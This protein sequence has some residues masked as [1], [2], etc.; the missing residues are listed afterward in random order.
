MYLIIKCSYLF[1]VILLTGSALK[2][3]CSSIQKLLRKPPKVP[4]GQE[5]HGYVRCPVL[6]FFN[7]RIIKNSD[8]EKTQ[9]I[10]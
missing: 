7:V 9:R 3:S 4:Q 6:L 2:N 1:T 8:I 5:F 10:M